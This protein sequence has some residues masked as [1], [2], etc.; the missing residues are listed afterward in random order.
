MTMV[1]FVLTLLVM[2]RQGAILRD[3]ARLRERRATQMVEA[4]YASL[5]ANASDVILIV[6]SDGALRFASPAFERTFGLKPEQALGQT[7]FDVWQ[8]GDR[9]SLKEYLTELAAT[10]TGPVGP[11]ELHVERG[12]ERITLEIVGRNLSDDPAV[13]GLALNLRDISERKS[14]E[15]QLRELAFHDP[16][17]RLANRNLFRDRVQH[18]LALARRTKRHVAVMFLDLDDFKNVNDTLGHDA[19]DRLLQAVAERLVDTMRTTDTV[20]RLAGDEF[21]VLL[22]GIDSVADIER[23]AAALVDA[24][25]ESFALGESGVQVGISVG[26]ALST[27]DSDRRGAAEQRRH[28]DV[29]RQGRGQG[30]LR[31][32]RAAHAGGAPRAAAPRGR[33]RTCAHKRRVL[34]GVPARRRASHAQADRRRG[35]GTLAASRTRRAAAPAVHPPGGGVGPHRRPEPL[36]AAAGVRGLAA[37]V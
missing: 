13:R 16:L 15:E 20:A 17:T 35:A 4:R 23:P 2:L 5:I 6:A 8:G 24:L 34:P 12:A 3:D 22:E 36:R 30:S 31:H 19:G 7:L 28:R 1:V 27:P 26:V 14:L 10:P 33:H 11:V 25:G 37:L 32:L 21:A 18:S 9:E 29:Q